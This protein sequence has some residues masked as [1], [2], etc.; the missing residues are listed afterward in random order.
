[1]NYTC[2]RN[3]R[4]RKSRILSSRIVFVA[5]A[6]FALLT[7]A[8]TSALMFAPFTGSIYTSDGSCTGVNLNI[9]SDRNAVYLDGGPNGGGSVLATG[10][11]YVKLTD[12]AVTL[13]GT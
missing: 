9:F 7:L 13:L 11:Y 3:S 5:L 1:M 4:S 6:A 12:P 10:Y 2:P 8:T